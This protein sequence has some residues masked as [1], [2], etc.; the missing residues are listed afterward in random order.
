ML[1]CC[2]M[3]CV[4][5][6]HVPE[7]PTVPDEVTVDPHPRIAGIEPLVCTSAAGA[8]VTW[9]HEGRPITTGSGQGIVAAREVIP[10]TWS[11]TAD[12]A[13]AVEV[14]ITPHGGNLLLILLDDVGIDNIG[15]Y[16]VGADPPATPN[17]DALAAS[18]VR[19]TDAWALPECSPTR[20]SL[21]TGRYPRRHGIGSVIPHHGLDVLS[22]T[23]VTLPEVL[24]TAPVPYT[25]ALV[26]KWHLAPLYAWWLH[27]PAEQGFAVH[28]GS[29]DNLQTRLQPWV[30]VPEP[31]GYYYWEKNT[32]GELSWSTTYATTD[33]TD[34]ALAQ[35]A[36]LPEPWFLYVSYNAAHQPWDLPPPSLYDG[37]AD[38]EIEAF[39]ASIV[40]AD[41]EI[42][43]LLSG[44]DPDLE[45]RT[46]V[47]LLA[48][49]GTPLQV[50]EPPVDPWQIKG[51][52]LEGGFRV[53][54]IVSGPLVAEPGSTSGAMVHVVDVLPTAAAI[55]GAI[56]DDGVVRDGISFLP[57][58]HRPDQASA[59]EVLWGEK[60]RPNGPGPYDDEC[61]TVRDETHQLVLLP[62]AELL[63][64][65]G[66]GPLDETEV[67]YAGEL[68]PDD[69]EALDRLRAA[70]VA[71]EAALGLQRP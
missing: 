59:R 53:P 70:L 71:E 21:L 66:P 1:L 32:D 60:F 25:S 39:D 24:Q 58:L 4:D 5:D 11:C 61:R 35:M 12:G 45:G 44:M 64:R 55:A 56:L 63:F 52:C 51:S 37:S 62:E 16:G 23:E 67:L 65:R 7:P 22:N 8:S 30:S 18:G 6:P 33:T 49:N 46:T 43:R 41:A 26:G 9:S 42:G 31:L 69:A 28:A 34:D 14:E 20:A 57:Y 40:A 3:G 47:V 15:L 48:D 36:D 10:G 38:D 13:D 54:M 17:I 2:W 27:H 29:M 19:F 68:D 50:I